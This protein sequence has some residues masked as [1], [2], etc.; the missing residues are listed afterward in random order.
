MAKEN[1][2]LSEGPG[3]TRSAGF[4]EDELKSELKNTRVMG[5]GWAEETVAQATRVA[6]RIIGSSVTT[7]GV[8]STRDRTVVGSGAAGAA[9]ITPFD[10][11]EHVEGLCAEFNRYALRDRKVLKQRHVEVGLAGITQNIPAGISKRESNGRYE[12]RRISVSGTEG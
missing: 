1:P 3:F 8:G 5:Q 4:S 10:M 9:D 2:G 12:S 11:V 7:D 6:R